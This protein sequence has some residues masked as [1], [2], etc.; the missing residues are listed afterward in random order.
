MNNQLPRLKQLMKGIPIKLRY[1]AV[2]RP[3]EVR[4]K[5]AHSS[6]GTLQLFD[7][8]CH[9]QE[10][11][12]FE[13]DK[14]SQSLR[15]PVWLAQDRFYK[16]CLCRN[17]NQMCHA[18]QVVAQMPLGLASSCNHL[19]ILKWLLSDSGGADVNAADA[20]VIRHHLSV[21]HDT[22]RSVLICPLQHHPKA[23]KFGIVCHLCVNTAVARSAANNSREGGMNCH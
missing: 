17:Y 19:S 10:L 11:Q 5:F 18:L 8:I 20:N 16:H 6:R 22:S 12:A 2:T 13:V 9:R 23:C 14:F 3:G 1:P 15:D 4:T 21:W 7:M